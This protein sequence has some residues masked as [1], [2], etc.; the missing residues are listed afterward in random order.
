[1]EGIARILEGLAKLF[2]SVAWPCGIFGIVWLLQPAL[3]TLVRNIG[4][5]SIKG[6]GIEATGKRTGEIAGSLVAAEL[7]RMN[8]ALSEQD[9][10]AQTELS[11]NEAVKAAERATALVAI[12]GV[13]GRSVLWVNDNP[14][15]DFYERRSLDALGLSISMATTT[16]GALNLLKSNKYD[17]V[18]TDLGR[19]EGRQ[20]GY[21]LLIAMKKR[22]IATP[23][24]IYT[25][26]KNQETQHEALLKGAYG[27]TSDPKELIFYVI[28]ALKS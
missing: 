9:N 15:G 28:S 17:V 26:V 21:D 22:G 16:E 1:M 27:L 25:S 24:I 14:S 10:N 12:G 4:E 13:Y 7:L 8:P 18:I 2:S 11:I 23:V 5:F 19:P 3:S 20:A 6:L